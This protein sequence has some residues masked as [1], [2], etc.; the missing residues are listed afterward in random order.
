M[1]PIKTPHSSWFEAVGPVHEKSL[2]VFCFP[3]AGG[4]AQVYRGWQ[5]HLPRQVSLSLVHLPGR[6]RRIDEPPFEHLRPLLEMLA[7]E[8]ATA[9]REPYAFWGHSMGAL[10][11]FE[12]ARELRRRGHALPRALFVSGCRAPQLPRSRPSIF[13][14]PE[15][16]FIA[17]LKRLNGT[18]EELLQ[19]PETVKLF[20]PTTR[21]DFQIVETYLYK[22]EDALSCAIYA[23]GGLQDA[24]VSAESL[25]AWQKQTSSKFR[26]RMLPG[27]HFFIHSSTASLTNVL[28]RDLQEQ[29]LLLEGSER[30]RSVKS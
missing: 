5:Q 20:L 19:D 21:A 1:N 16:E 24:H 29:L 4:S 12:L 6:G 3:Y 18:P 8:F 23:Y 28:S 26:A 30:L 22:P 15:R 7:E 14:L 17:E 11:S 13:G 9:P 27:D 25:N 2:Q 10:I